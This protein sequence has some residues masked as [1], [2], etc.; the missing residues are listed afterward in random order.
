MYKSSSDV[1]EVKSTEYL[2]QTGYDRTVASRVVVELKEGCGHQLVVSRHREEGLLGE[3]DKEEPL[4]LLGVGAVGRLVG[5]LG[6]LKVRTPPVGHN[7]ERRKERGREREMERVVPI[8]NNTV[9][10]YT[11]DHEI[12]AIKFFRR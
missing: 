4:V 10:L 3:R 2:G 8:I 9:G 12:F 11:V 6:G 1:N 5:I 7:L